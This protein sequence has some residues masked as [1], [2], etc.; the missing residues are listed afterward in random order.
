ARCL[1]YRRAHVEP[2][3]RTVA[4]AGTYAVRGDGVLHVARRAD[5]ARSLHLVANLGS[6]VRD[7]GILPAGERFVAHGD[8]VEGEAPALPPF[9][10]VCV[11]AHG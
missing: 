2:F 8:P 10:V 11:V 3:A 6:G 4:T 9:T 1:A 5:D 7:A